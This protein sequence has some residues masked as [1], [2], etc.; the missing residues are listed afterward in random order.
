[1]WLSSVAEDA[2][3]CYKCYNHEELNQVRRKRVVERMLVFLV[4]K[5]FFNEEFQ[6]KELEMVVPLKC[7]VT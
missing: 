2:N 4:L 7:N 6:D 3:E 1:M 5:A